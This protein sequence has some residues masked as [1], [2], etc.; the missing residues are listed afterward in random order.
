MWLWWVMGATAVLLVTAA[1]H[2]RRRRSEFR[3]VPRNL[4]RTDRREALRLRRAELAAYN[5]EAVGYGGGFGMHGGG[6]HCG[7]FDGGGGDG[8]GGC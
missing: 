3:A 8:G 6:G 4:S 1:V 5:H 7:G 2:D